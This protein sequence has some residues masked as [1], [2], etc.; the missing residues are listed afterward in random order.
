MKTISNIERA[1]FESTYALI[2]RSEETHRSRF[3]LFIYTLLVATTL[4]AISQFGREVAR[5]PLSLAQ[6]SQ[7]GPAPYR[8]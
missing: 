5:T 8:I 2:V 1:P 7:V 6:G 3:E 4:F